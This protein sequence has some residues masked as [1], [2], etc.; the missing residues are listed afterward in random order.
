MSMV[1]AE[2]LTRVISPDDP[3]L[4]RKV[5]EAILTMGSN[6]RTSSA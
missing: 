1:E 6:P 2:I 5:A 3:S 4:N